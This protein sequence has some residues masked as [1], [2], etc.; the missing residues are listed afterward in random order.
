MISEAQA[1]ALIAELQ[2]GWNAGDGK[3]FAAPFAEDADFVTVAG[4]HARGRQAIADNHDRIFSTVY[5]G[6]RVSMELAQL[7]PLRNGLAL[8]H[9]APTLEVPEGQFAGTMN[10]LMTTV[11]DGSGE[12]PQ[13]V[14]LH[15]TI[16]RDLAQAAGR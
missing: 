2:A 5:K 14:A 16:V 15:N 6:S 7:R 11:V 10:A 13:I 12:R 8:M 4:Q 3:A 1:K 9:I